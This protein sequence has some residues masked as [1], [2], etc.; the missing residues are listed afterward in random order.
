MEKIEPGDE[1]LTKHEYILQYIRQLKIGE[2]IS[3]RSIAKALQVSEGTAYRALKEAEKLGIVS[4]RERIG[5]VRIEKKQ[6]SQPDR[7]TFAEIAALLDGQVLGG[8]SG[9]DKTLQKFVIGAMKLEEMIAYID[10]DSLLIVG[11]REDAHHY[12]LEEGAGVLITG[13]FDT[14]DEV[15]R[16]SDER[17]L[18][19]ISCKHDTFTVASIINRAMYDRIIQRKIMRIEDIVAFEDKP[20]ALHASDTV[21]SFG[22]LQQETGQ[23]R[24]PVVDEKSRIIGIMT[25]RDAAGNPGSQTVEKLMTRNPITVRPSTTITSAAHTMASE[26]IDLLPIVDR[27][28]R[29][30]AVVTRQE[31]LAAMPFAGKQPQ[32]GETFDDL[33]WSGFAKITGERTGEGWLYRGR[34]TPQMSGPLGTVS[35]GVLMSLLM[36]AGRLLIWEIGKRDHVLESVTTYFVRPTQIDQDISIVPRLLEMNRKSAKLEIEIVDDRG[37]AAKAM[38]S[39]QMIDPY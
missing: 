20:K 21:N 18:P 33:M 17:G 38:M 9:L 14:S 32:S 25:A 37:L 11:N 3:V 29:L 13:G 31:V 6:R 10:A 7:L 1:A 26:G 22:L 4:T 36:Q 39:A 28:R 16:L 30:L 35:E 27:Q 19:V 15:K 8:A 34:M 24:F 2:K 23:A 5:T 12:A